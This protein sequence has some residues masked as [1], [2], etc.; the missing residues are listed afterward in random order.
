MGFAQDYNLDFTV[1]PKYVQDVATAKLKWNVAG[2][3]AI[4]YKKPTK[5]QSSA[6]T[7]TRADESGAGVAPKYP[8]KKAKES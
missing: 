7:L 5:S 4:K 1:L 2:R 8:K 6:G 3:L